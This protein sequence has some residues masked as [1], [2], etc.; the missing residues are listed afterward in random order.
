[1]SDE[2]QNHQ[3]TEIDIDFTDADLTKVSHVFFEE[4]KEL[5][6]D[7]DDY[8][9]KLEE[10]PDD[11]Q[12]INTLFRRVHTLKGSV[13]AV[14]GGQLFGQVAHEFENMLSRL[15]TEHRPATKEVIDIFLKSSRLLKIIADC[16]RNN[17]EI[18]P[19][20][21]SESID[22]IAEFNNFSF[23]I[24]TILVGKKRKKFTVENG[25]EDFSEDGVWLS[26]KQLHE[27]MRISGELLV[28][29]NYHQMLHQTIDIREQYEVYE[30][31]QTEFAQN[32]T[33]ISDL[34]QTQIMLV[35]KATA[36]DCFNGLNAVIRQ[37]SAELN[38]DVQ[39]NSEGMDEYIDK[40]LGKDLFEFAI[41]LRGQGL[42]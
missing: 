9:L 10:N 28:L 12:L 30:R 1:M 20:A 37:G 23:D 13:G 42:V 39:L 18:Y 21:V 7:L 16:L 8:I 15:K 11:S 6:N 22:L 29:K 40:A 24:G 33:K 4:S 14:S 25:K 32:L 19:E 41:K 2:D 5:L 34:L 27:L 26:Q 31:R 17:I 38:K 36:Q 35:R 3:H